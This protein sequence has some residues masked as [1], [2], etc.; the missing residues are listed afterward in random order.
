MGEQEMENT[1]FREAKGSE[2]RRQ[3]HQHSQSQTQSSDDEGSAATSSTAQILERVQSDKVIVTKPEED[4]RRRTIIVE[5]KSGSFG[6]TI[7]SYG[8]HYKKEKEIEMITYVDYVD[9]DGPAYRAGM[10]EGDVILSIN[11]TDMEKADHK[12][13]VNYIKNCESRM[14]M[15]VLFEDCVRKVEL[16]MRYI[17]LQNILESKMDELE[18]LC[19]K[20]RQLLE[21][22]WKTHSL[23]ARKKASQSNNSGPPTPQGYYSFCRPTVS[24]EDVAKVAQRTQP[25]TPP[26]VFTYQYLDNSYRY[27]LQPSNHSSGEYLLTFE[28]QRYA[29][30]RDPNFIVKTPCDSTPPKQPTRSQQSAE[31]PKKGHGPCHSYG[32]HLCS[33]CVTVNTNNGDNTSLEAY[34]LASPCCDPH[35]VP[36]R[37]RSRSQKSV[38][39][40]KRESK[41][42]ETQTEPQQIPRSRPHSQATQNS[43][44]VTSQGYSSVPRRYFHIGAGLVS[45][46]SLH[47]CTSSEISNAVPTTVGESS[48]NSYTTS[49][50]TDTLYW[51][52]STENASRQLSQKS[53]GERQSQQAQYVQYNQ[54]K[55]KSWDNL[56]TKAFGG[57]GFGYG[58]LDT[59]GSRCSQK[60]HPKKPSSA[61]QYVRVDKSA[62]L[63]T[64]H[65]QRRYFHPTKSTESLLSATKYP[66]ERLTEPSL[67]CECLDPGLPPSEPAGDSRFCPSSR[68]RLLSPTDPNLGYYSASRRASRTEPPSGK[69]PVT[70]S[71]EATRL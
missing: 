65:T 15:V 3:S 19:I 24:T 46:C 66:S 54:V 26:L 7:Q 62:P 38:Q 27:L 1:N 8:I 31:K 51:E 61:M 28:P 4:R 5:K 33:P 23:P 2:M 6:F 40:R 44:V 52:G 67:S 45:Q 32:G 35:C 16:H 14:R 29:D 55:P 18:R 41:T 70:T 11:G 53:K 43:P 58:C 36:A 20:E 60:N 37:R 25:A 10:R 50:S 47:S 68:P 9:Y 64:P 48:A 13:L 42:E 22:K 30:S 17:K 59:S 12:T 49:L 21:G 56:T 69:P 63:Y 71:S 39:G 34:D 57:Y